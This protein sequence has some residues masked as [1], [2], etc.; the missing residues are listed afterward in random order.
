M[1]R[2]IYFNDQ[3]DF[4]TIEVYDE[5]RNHLLSPKGVVAYLTIAQ[6]LPELSFFWSHLLP[7]HFS[8]LYLGGFYGQATHNTRHWSDFVRRPHPRPLP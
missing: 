6:L 5:P 3:P 2:S 7:Q 8:L 4:V 1:Y